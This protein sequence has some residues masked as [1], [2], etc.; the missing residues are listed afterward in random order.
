VSTIANSA[1]LHRFFKSVVQR[2]ATFEPD[3]ELLV[4]IC[5]NARLVTKGWHI[6]P[7]GALN[8]SQTRIREVPLPML[9]T[10]IHFCSI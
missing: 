3:K 10:G 8:E 2:D 9:L 6:V 1:A 5:L 4:V 7:I